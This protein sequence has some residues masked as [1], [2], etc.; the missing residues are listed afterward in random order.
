MQKEKIRQIWSR[1]TD[2]TS[3]EDKF[4]FIISR[5]CRKH[6]WRPNALAVAETSRA[7]SDQQLGDG[8]VVDQCRR[9]NH[10]HNIA[11]N[12]DDVGS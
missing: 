1:H 10:D 6:N 7:E 5:T 4:E 12:P 3:L 9:C 8:R 2:S 11:V